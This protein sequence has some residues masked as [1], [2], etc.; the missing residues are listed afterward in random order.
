MKCPSLAHIGTE[1]VSVHSVP[2]DFHCFFKSIFYMKTLLSLLIYS[3]LN[4]DI[5]SHGWNPNAT[6]S[7]FINVCAPIG[8]L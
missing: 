1:P 4:P 6:F 3:Y 8:E 5:E 7:L 2:L